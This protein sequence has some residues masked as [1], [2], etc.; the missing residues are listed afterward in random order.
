MIK[1]YEI[2]SNGFIGA[3][4]EIDPREGVTA[5]WTYTPPPDDGCYRWEA[6]A[7]I[8]G[9]EPISYDTTVS[10]DQVSSD[11]RTE[12][13]TRL[14]DTDW[15]QARDV[16]EAIAAKWAPYRQALRDIPEQSG[17]PFFVEWPEKPE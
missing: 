11:V 13:N 1:V 5:G 2:K 3:T 14:A 8:P 4:K 9:I 17:F 6:G 10:S 15:T 12:R 7:W 16:P